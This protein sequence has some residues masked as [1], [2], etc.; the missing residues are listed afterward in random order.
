MMDVEKSLDE[1]E[2]LIK[3]YGIKE[4]FDDSGVWYRGKEARA[5]AQ[6]IIDRGLH[7]SGC[8]F[9]INTRFEYLDEETIKLMG[10]ANFRFVLLGYEAADNE[11][12]ERL[13]KGYQLEH[14]DQCLEWLTKYGMHPHL[15]IMVGY[16]WQTKQQL[17]ST[18]SEVKRLMLSGLAR[19]LQVTLCTPLDY[20]PYHKECE[21][22]GVLLTDDYNDFDMSKLIVKTPEP[23]EYYYKAV[24]DMYSIAFHP[25]FILR[26]IRFL[27]NFKKRDW[28][29][30]FT[31][32]IRAVR[33]VRQHIFNLTQASNS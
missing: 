1:C 28:Q 5:F 29:F 10:K 17:D 16:Y 30:L 33:R 26:Q 8:Y 11:T 4:I 19:T 12:L 3:N 25:L 13:N 20:T 6:G 32:S 15:T 7:K 2:N 18:V 21:M 14:V 24:K 23:H 31:Y 9:G 27:L 22:A